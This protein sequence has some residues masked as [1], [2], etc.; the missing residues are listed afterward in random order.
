MS[1]ESIQ[2]VTV[3]CGADEMSLELEIRPEQLGSW[4]AVV[5]VLLVTT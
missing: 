5:I 1:I 3:W 2:T 4:E